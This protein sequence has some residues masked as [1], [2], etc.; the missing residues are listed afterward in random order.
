MRRCRKKEK[1]GM[2]IIDNIPVR[3]ALVDEAALK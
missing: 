3:G 1:S 2:E